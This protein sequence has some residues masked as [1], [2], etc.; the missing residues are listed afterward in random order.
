MKQHGSP[1]R[2]TTMRNYGIQNLIFQ[3]ATMTLHAKPGSLLKWA[4]STRWYQLHLKW[5]VNTGLLL[6]I[7][8]QGLKPLTPPS[9]ELPGERETWTLG[10][11]RNLIPPQ[12]IK[13]VLWYLITWVSEIS[14]SYIIV[15][16]LNANISNFVWLRRLIYVYNFRLEP[17]KVIQ[18]PW[19]LVELSFSFWVCM[20]VYVCV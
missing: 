5:S 20:C 11:T 15:N 12:M 14:S 16:K 19:R 6:P 8:R 4:P 1:S 10:L 18:F 13:K 3:R 7:H 9:L 2:S 17:Q